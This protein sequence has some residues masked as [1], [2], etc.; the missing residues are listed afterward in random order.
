MLN[1]HTW[2]MHAAFMLRCLITSLLNVAYVLR[3]QQTRALFGHCTHHRIPTHH[4]RR[5]QASHRAYGSAPHRAYGSASHRA[6]P[7]VCRAR[8]LHHLSPGSIARA[9]TACRPCRLL[10]GR[11]R[12]GAPGELPCPGAPE[13]ERAHYPAPLPLHIMYVPPTPCKACARG[14]ARQRACV[15]APL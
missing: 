3:A 7:L 9:L 13:R 2:T 5:L 11:Q 15:C 14:D 8:A 6:A 4:L 1:R 12:P 10:A